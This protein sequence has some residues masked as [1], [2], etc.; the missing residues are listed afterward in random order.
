MKLDLYPVTLQLKERFTIAHDS[1]I[2]QKSLIVALSLN[3][4][5]GYGEATV[6]KFYHISMEDMINCLSRIRDFL[7][8]YNLQTPEKL[9]AD[10]V[11]EMQG[12]MFA[13]CALDVAAHDLYG[14]LHAKPTY[15]IWGMKMPTIQSNYTIGI[16]SK[17]VMVQKV[18]EFPWPIYKIKLGMEDDIEIIRA[19]REISDSIFR[20]DANC[21]WSADETIEKSN[22][23]KELG[24][25]FIEQPMHP[26]LILEMKRVKSKSVLPLIADED[27]LI[28]SDVEKCAGKFDGINIK[29]MK[30]GGLTPARRMIENARKLG[31]KVM[32]G[33]MT[34]SSVGISA[35]S[36]LA[37]LID[38]VD[39]DGNLLIKSDVAEGV[40]LIAGEIVFPK[41]N[42]NGVKLFENIEAL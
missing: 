21:A 1:R 15:E 39:M 20:V 9:W 33:C 8:V 37:A 42:G 40:K 18:K 10:V 16:A 5:T 27:C 32:V 34:E 4:Q 22:V 26:D 3:G 38:Y 25:E 35:I 30:C 41:R 19:I 2:E 11:D 29:L 13:L 31:L 24:V 14:K 6:N 23:L 28:E 12:N 7:Q 17:Q 36:Q